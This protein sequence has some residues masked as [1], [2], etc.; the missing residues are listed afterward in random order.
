MKV[1]VVLSLVALCYSTP[2]T[3]NR[4]VTVGEDGT[5]TVTG[6][7]GRELNI[8]QSIVNPGKLDIIFKSPFGI[9]RKIQIDEMTNNI[10][11]VPFN[12]L[13][14]RFAHNLPKE[15]ITQASILAHI[16]RQYEGIVDEPT[17]LVLLEKV[18]TLVRHGYVHQA[19]L[20]ALKTF[21]KIHLVE[22]MKKD[23]AERI[24]DNVVREQ[25][26]E[27]VQYP[28]QV[29]NKMHQVSGVVPVQGVYGLNQY[30]TVLPYQK[31]FG[32]QGLWNIKY[33]T[34]YQRQVLLQQL[35]QKIQFERLVG[36]VNPVD[37]LKVEEL[38][39]IVEPMNQYRY[40]QTQ[41]S[42]L[43]RFMNNMGLIKGQQYYQQ[44]QGQYVP[45]QYQGQY[46]PQQWQQLKQLHQLEQLEQLEKMEVLRELGQQQQ[47]QQYYQQQYYQ[48]TY[49]QGIYQQ[50]QMVPQQYE[51]TRFV[52]QQFGYGRIP[53][54][55]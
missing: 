5:I 7:Q 2:L 34:P 12:F 43:T 55:Y 4:H 29:Y 37:V 20:E 1:L 54:V 44:Y 47:Q 39:Q 8:Y 45:Q 42:P 27:G 14:A 38:E 51:Q 49:P 17:Y 15:V 26:T 48:H 46:V 32:I 52:N 22:E 40:T 21:E 24:V 23:E 6:I 3:A 35:K 16:F 30:K 25:L 9:A 50:R 10:E 28:T 18:E 36:K 53:M 31:F 33:M 41:V 19:V 13:D 11:N